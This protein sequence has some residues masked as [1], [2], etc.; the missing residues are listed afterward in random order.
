MVA[1]F[2]LVALRIET[3]TP[4]P[5]AACSESLAFTALGLC[6]SRGLCHVWCQPL[7]HGGQP[8]S[9]FPFSFESEA[10]KAVP[11]PSVHGGELVIWRA[12]AVTRELVIWRALA[13]TSGYSHFTGGLP[14]FS[15]RHFISQKKKKAKQN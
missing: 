6:I 9:L 10:L 14:G 13:V 8:A 15:L 1:T 2:S 11:K 4:F 5:S 7:D 12:L 3:I